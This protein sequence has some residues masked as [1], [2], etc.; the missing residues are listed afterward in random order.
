MK[1]Q[2]ELKDS[3]NS[4]ENYTDLEL[5]DGLLDD[6]DFW[7]DEDLEDINLTDIGLSPEE[8]GYNQ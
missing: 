6:D 8:L 4:I 2:I 5:V 3:E 7:E 1:I